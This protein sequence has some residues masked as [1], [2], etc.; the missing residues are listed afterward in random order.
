MV[1]TINF[2]LIPLSA[3]PVGP[4]SLRLPR[5]AGH[6]IPCGGDKP[7]LL[8]NGR[9]AR[10]PERKGVGPPEVTAGDNVACA[11]LFR[12]TGIAVLV[13][14]GCVFGATCLL[15]RGVARRVVVDQ[16]GDGRPSLVGCWYMPNAA[17]LKSTSFSPLPTPCI[18]LLGKKDVVTSTTAKIHFIAC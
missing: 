2:P 8:P 14:F 5:R 15:R 4:P 16:A 11:Q 6:T 1:E 17:G 18:M 3:S 7:L 10:A 12:L 13:S 9:W